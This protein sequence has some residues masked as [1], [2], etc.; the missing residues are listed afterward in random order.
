VRTRVWLGALLVLGAAALFAPTT[1]T[2]AKPKPITGKLSKRGYTVIAL[3]ANGKANSV[4]ARR[5]QFRLRPPARRVTLQLRDKNG[6]YAGPIVLGVA[7]KGKRAIV[8][9]KAGA[10][11][12]KVRVKR[13]K[14]YATLKRKLPRKFIDAKRQARAKKGVPIGNG[15]N[16]GRVRSRHAHGP[17][18]DPDRDGVPNPLDVDDNGNLVLDTF[19]RPGTARASQ[20]QGVP[21]FVAGRSKLFLDLPQTVNANAPGLT[22]QQVDAALPTFGGLFLGIAGIEADPGTQVELDCGDPNTGLVYCRQN[23]STGNLA[24]TRLGVPLLPGTSDGAP[25]PACCDPDGN[26]FGSLTRIVPPGGVV[27]YGIPLLHHATT[28]GVGAGDLVIVHATIGGSPTEFPGTVQYVFQTVPA[29]ASYSDGQGDA[30]PISYPV[31]PVDPG[32]GM[33]G[34]PGTSGNPLPVKA[35]A[36][37]NVLVTLTV[38]RPQRR[39]FVN[40]AG[41][42]ID[43]GHNIYTASISNVGIGCPLGAYSTTDPNLTPVAH[44]PVALGGLEDSADDQAANPAHTLTFTL[45]LT[46]CLASGGQTFNS[47]EA[48]GIDLGAIPANTTPGGPPDSATTQVWF[49]RQ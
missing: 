40:E 18:S 8:G 22:D 14:G 38:W 47:G 48:L 19:D 1:T 24:G 36:D 17:S 15:R 43:I 33:G 45:N 31:A 13:R 4:V 3:A 11:L 10:K 7:K 26:G 49:K 37:G 5:S 27:L 23:G 34:G 28:A 16:F 2:A 20:A 32:T 46:Q 39:P 30:A 29:V 6:V 35:G 41:K 12:G 9:V 21:I 25:Y 42:W 44:Q